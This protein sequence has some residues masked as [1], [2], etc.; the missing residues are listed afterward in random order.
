MELNLKSQ[1]ELAKAKAIDSETETKRLGTTHFGPHNK[2]ES[3][4]SLVL[5]SFETLTWSKLTTLIAP[6]DTPDSKL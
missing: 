1:T 6:L 5:I 4:T 3:M 2:Q